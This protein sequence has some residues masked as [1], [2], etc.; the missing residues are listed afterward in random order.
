ML[1][2]TVSLGLGA[3]EFFTAHHERNALC[4]LYDQGCQIVLTNLI[5]FGIIRIAGTNLIPK[6]IVI[7][8]VCI[9]DDLGRRR[10]PILG[11]LYAG[12]NLSVESGFAVDITGIFCIKDAALDSI[13]DRIAEAG[14]TGHS[15][16]IRIS[17][18][19]CIGLGGSGVHVP[20]FTVHNDSGMYFIN[21]STNCIHGIYIEDTHQVETE[22]VEVIFFCPVL[23]GINNELA[24]HGALGSNIVAAA[25]SILAG[26]VEITGNESV[27]AVVSVV[28]MVVNNVHNHANT[29]IMESLYH[30]LEF[31]D[32]YFAVIRVSR[33]GAFGSIVVNRIITPVELRC[34]QLGFINGTVIIYGQEMNGS[35]TQILQ[36][37]DTGSDT[38]LSS[39]ACFCK[40][41][42][43]A[44]VLDTAVGSDR[45]ISYMEF[46]DL[47]VGHISINLSL[48][49]VPAFG[50][51]G[52]EIKNH[53]SL[54][55]NAYCSGIGVNDILVDF[56]VK[57]S[58]IGVILAG[59]V[60]VSSSNPCALNVLCHGNNLLSIAAVAG[61]IDVEFYLFSGRCPYTEVRAAINNGCTEVI[62]G[63][64]E[65]IF[66]F[67]AGEIIRHGKCHCSTSEGNGV[68]F[69]VVK[70]LRKLES[71]AGIGNTLIGTD[72]YFCAGSRLDGESGGSNN[73]ILTGS[74][75]VFDGYQSFGFSHSLFDFQTCYSFAVIH[76]KSSLTG[77]AVNM[78]STSYYA[79]KVKLSVIFG[80]LGFPLAQ[81][82]DKA[83]GVDAL[84]NDSCLSAFGIAVVGKHKTG[85][86]G[87]A[88]KGCAAAFA[89]CPQTPVCIVAVGTQIVEYY[90]NAVCG[91]SGQCSRNQE[92]AQYQ[93]ERNNGGYDALR[94]FL[95]VHRRSSPLFYFSREICHKDTADNHTD[96]NIFLF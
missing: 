2:S 74:R 3:Q 83:E 96:Y 63:I 61:C 8:A 78:D 49:A 87:I 91:L 12:K 58:C 28:G 10:R 76:V 55:V 59:Q 70:L 54:A 38:V 89:P 94:E 20:A 29:G 71:S 73:L 14:N 77:L 52:V 47:H 95:C 65:F 33:V 16:S 57:V 25:G 42:I 26:S 18:H 48:V 75:G 22:A 85:S 90:L 6:G 23:H 27:E 32:S 84:S 50:I 1:K 60:T 4:G 51:S 88:V 92:A 35:N 19:L 17:S 79:G 81:S 45:E 34:I 80:I 5:G 44:L 13:T 9:V 86:C 15:S 43:L 82:D 62:T 36:V 72:R 46:I 39:S 7:V 21:G 69:E 56:A 67:L 66:K 41:K 31:V 11:V 40:G 24:D 30:L 64:G 93:H 37:V 53:T 68:L